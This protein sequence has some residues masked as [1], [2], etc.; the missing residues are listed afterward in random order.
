M[1]TNMEISRVVEGNRG[2]GLKVLSERRKGRSFVMDISK[3]KVSSGILKEANTLGCTEP[4]TPNLLPDINIDACFI[5]CK[6]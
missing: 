6:L 3:I 4:T 1:L 2:I 5:G